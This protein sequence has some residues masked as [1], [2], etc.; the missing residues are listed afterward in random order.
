MNGVVPLPLDQIG[1]QLPKPRRQRYTPL[2]LGIVNI[3]QYDYQEWWLEGGNLLLRGDN[4][5][6]KTKVIELTLPFLFDAQL[7]P[8]RLDPFGQREG[9][10]MH[11]NLLEGGGLGQNQREG[12]AWIEFGRLDGEGRDHFVT[13]GAWIRASSVTTKVDP[14]YFVTAKRVGQDLFFPKAGEPTIGKEGLRRQVGEIYTTRREYQ[15]AVD[16][17]LFGLGLERF[18]EMIDLLLQLRQPKL[19]ATLRPSKLTTI[20]VDSLPPVDEDQ[21]ATLADQYEQLEQYEARID[22]LEKNEKAVDSYLRTYRTFV[23]RH[24]KL[25]ADELR[26]ANHVVEDEAKRLD[27]LSRSLE[28]A[29]SARRELENEQARAREAK[30]AVSGRLEAVRQAPE[31]TTV[32]HLEQAHSEAQKT[33]EA[34]KEAEAAL[35]LINEDVES[36]VAELARIEHDLRPAQ[37]QLSHVQ[38]AAEKAAASADLAALHGNL[39]SS[40]LNNPDG[41]IKKLRAVAHAKRDQAD[42]LKALVEQIPPLEA[43]LSTVR[44]QIN[45]QD[46]LTETA[47]KAYAA[48]EAA[49][50]QA[51]EDHLVAIQA[52]QVGLCEL[53]LEAGEAT[54]LQEQALDLE[55]DPQTLLEV[56]RLRAAAALEEAVGASVAAIRQ[57]ESQIDELEY[58]IKTLEQSAEIAP[59]IPT[60]RTA[61]RRARSGAPFYRCVDFAPSLSADQA[62]LLEAGLEASG[63]L[64]AWVWPDGQIDSEVIDTS[65]LTGPPRANALV[66]HLQPIGGAVE[67]AVI[68][69][70]LRS[71]GNSADADS[72]VAIDGSW[73]LGALQ[74]R[75]YKVSAEF[76]GAS[77][78]EEARQRKLRELGN[79]RETF[80]AELQGRQETLSRL[81]HRQER[82]AAETASYPSRTTYL[83]A[84]REA[85]KVSIQLD[86]ASGQLR[87]LR[88]HEGRISSHL[89]EVL[90]GLSGRAAELS[91]TGFVDRLP[92]LLV[93][94]RE[95]DEQI[96]TLWMA[97]SSVMN[98]GKTAE[99]AEQDLQVRRQRLDKESEKVERRRRDHARAR[100][101][102]EELERSAEGQAALDALR[103]VEAL[104]AELRVIEDGI[105]ERSRKIAEAGDALGEARGRLAELR[106]KHAASSDRRTRAAEAIAELARRGTIDIALNTQIVIDGEW[107][108]SR[109]LDLARHQIEP[110]L[111][112]ELTHAEAINNA[113]NNLMSAF[114]DL[115]STL[116]EYAPALDWHGNIPQTT[117]IYNQA[118]VDIRTLRKRLLDEIDAQRRLLTEKEKDI[119]EHFLMADLANHLRERILRARR[120]VLDINDNLR[121]H[122]TNSGMT[123]SLR[124]SEQVE[125]SSEKLALE[126]L[127][128]DPGLLRD[129]ERELLREFFQARIAA[130]RVQEGNQTWREHLTEALDYRRW[131]KLSIYQHVD[132]KTTPFNDARYATGSGGEKSVSIHQPLFAAAA[133]YYDSATTGWAPRLIVLDEA[134]AG[135]DFPTR[136]RCLE[137]AELFDLD[138]VMTSYEEMGTHEEVSALAI[139]QMVRDP[140]RRGVYCERWIWNGHQLRLAEGA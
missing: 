125:G 87:Q 113:Q 20:L 47:R 68:E 111:Q 37:D 115:N 56:P 120:Q 119:F 40:L 129:H 91:L 60:V 67:A 88:E 44:E 7:H 83:Q 79:S 49:V 133:T 50:Q 41:T 106:E 122:P 36:A 63:I 15:H 138:L 38:R 80:S 55:A 136:G 65:V 43:S 34:L 109:A 45:E 96:T 92:E 35:D 8:N 12:Y 2:R 74:G 66:E 17:A 70:L 100:S 23:R 4:A 85:E 124:L 94:I 90:T 71:V 97:A 25:A 134:F 112:N 105:E 62:A 117:A 26:N 114:A 108:M 121:A 78:R 82:L 39:V 27:A 103:R 131:H 81:R 59:S 135:I 52:W 11:W 110:G 13:I 104:K 53:A 30:D 69:R 14:A 33:V 54:T 102:A 93:A 58:Q 76:V 84:S 16:Q 6:G 128:K 51:G 140:S 64:D 48:A 107:S 22:E 32:Y 73:R 29:H 77:A 98:L 130:A 9:R 132:G 21:I 10:S 95:Y 18:R 127:M 19:S 5:V 123:L 28:S 101:L 86:L 3:W 24:V 46:A 137:M 42:E 126:Y 1:P 139:Y 75:A 99:R 116:H 118:P 72:F 61:D 57:L 31:M 89:H